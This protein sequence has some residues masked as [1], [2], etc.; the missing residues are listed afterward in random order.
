MRAMVTRLFLDRYLSSILLELILVM[1]DTECRA[2]F[3]IFLGVFDGSAYEIIV[4]DTAVVPLFKASRATGELF[5]R[6]G[7]LLSHLIIYLH[8]VLFLKNNL[9]PL[10]KN[11]CLNWA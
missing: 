11:R 2:C 3:V 9:F 5:D 8:L 4:F 7:E 6:A 1:D 10:D